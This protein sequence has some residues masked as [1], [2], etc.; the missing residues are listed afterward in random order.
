MGY[1][2]VCLNCRKAFSQ[3]TDYTN[4]QRDKLCPDCGNSMVFLSAKFRPP[5]K[6]DNKKWE[7]VEFLVENGFYYESI[8]DGGYVIYPETMKEA[9]EFVE[10]YKTQAIK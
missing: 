4:F 3:G 2:S 1:K 5:K 8:Y 10:K 7:V 9:K 6:R